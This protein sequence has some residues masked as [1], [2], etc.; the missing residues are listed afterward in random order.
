M[1]V[2]FGVEIIINDNTA[3]AQRR[4]LGSGWQQDALTDHCQFRQ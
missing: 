4:W 3:A 1:R 2:I